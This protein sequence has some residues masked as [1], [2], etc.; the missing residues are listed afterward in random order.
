MPRLV[1]YR[2]VRCGVI[3]D[4][5]YHD[6]GAVKDK[7]RCKCGKMAH[8][9]FGAQL[10]ID[11]WSPMT[12][13]AQR[14]IEHF[15]RKKIVNGKYVDQRGIYREDRMKQDIPMNIEEV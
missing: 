14:D 9:I 7:I 13:D 2:C 4:V 5:F 12:N 10:F 8:R 6:P 11:D 1:D 15:A 3:P